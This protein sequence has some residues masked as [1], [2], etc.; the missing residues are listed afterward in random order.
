M[1]PPCSLVKPFVADQL[2]N[3]LENLLEEA[4]LKLSSFVSDL[5][6]L[7]A[8]RMLQAVADGET[9]HLTSRFAAFRIL[10]HIHD[11][12]TTRADKTT[13]IWPADVMPIS[14]CRSADCSSSVH[15]T[16]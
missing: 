14:Y 6:G 3:R 1:L 2:H 9:E 4:R 10:H 12:V 16:V 8:G 13:G 11:F 5:L 15:A 7:G